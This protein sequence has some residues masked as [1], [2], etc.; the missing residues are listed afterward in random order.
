MSAPT[1]A[2]ASFPGLAAP[3]TQASVTPLAVPPRDACG[4]LSLSMSR[5]YDLLRAGELQSYGD[6]RTR[7]ITMASIH[8]YI[9]RRLAD[10][11]G[12]WRTWPH[13]PQSRRRQ[14]ERA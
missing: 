4:L 6:G 11:A 2:R 12:G 13:N 14:R 9:A 5:L 10:S 7:R 8:A 3:S 1:S